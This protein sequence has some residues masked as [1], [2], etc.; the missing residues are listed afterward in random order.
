MWIALILGLIGIHPQ[1][2]TWIPN[3]AIFERRYNL[4]NHHVWYL[5]KI[6]GV[7]H[8][9]TTTSQFTEPMTWD[10]ETLNGCPSH[11]ASTTPI[12]QHSKDIPSPS[13]EILQKM[14][15]MNWKFIHTLSLHIGP[16]IW[17][18]R[19]FSFSNLPGQFLRKRS[20]KSSWTTVDGKNPANQLIWQ[21]SHYLQGCIDPRWLAGF[22]SINSTIQFPLF[23]KL[24]HHSPTSLLE[25]NHLSFFSKVL[26]LNCCAHELLLCSI[27]TQ[28]EHN[29]L[30]EGRSSPN[31]PRCPPDYLGGN[32]F[33][34]PFIWGHPHKKSRLQHLPNP[35]AY[36]KC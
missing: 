5:C 23:L 15:S 8:F 27:G 13:L 30:P 6:S 9:K 26:Q 12:G 34:L 29:V 24:R 1:K 35:T 28:G 22:L 36:C 4:K 33:F 25:Q 14:T 7:Y 31:Q 20:P 2:L 16:N 32:V 11:D 3:I 10:P 18:P 17:N 19:F 21:I